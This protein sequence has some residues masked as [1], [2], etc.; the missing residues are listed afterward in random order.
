MNI[1]DET[2]L[3]GRY[4]MAIYR[5]DKKWQIL[6]NNLLGFF[7]N[8]LKTAYTLK[9]AR[10]I[11]SW[12]AYNSVMNAGRA[13]IAS[14][15]GDATAVPFTYMEL[16]TSNTAVAVTQTALQAAITT[17]GLARAAATI[18][19]IQTNVAND[20]Y[21][22]VYTWTA[23]GSQTVEEIGIFN[24]AST[25]TILSRALTGSK[26]LV[27]GDQLMATYTLVNA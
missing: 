21:K 25:G 19:R 9:H 27:S 13:Q 8:G 4:D 10:L 6:W 5:F 12:T 2:K 14:L 22:A 24:A 17:S 3:T 11:D 7:D 1:K 16:G 18:S 20:T 26:S 15:I 23:S